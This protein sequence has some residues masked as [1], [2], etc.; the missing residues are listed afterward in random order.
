[1]PVNDAEKLADAIV[2]VMSSSEMRR[3]LSNNGIKIRNT[4]SPKIIYEKWNS[5]IMETCHE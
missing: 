4:L 2:R 5:A 3:K 1:M